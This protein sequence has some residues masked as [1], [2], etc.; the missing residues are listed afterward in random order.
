[1]HIVNSVTTNCASVV[2]KVILDGWIFH[3]GQKQNEVPYL[4]CVLFKKNTRLSFSMLPDLEFIKAESK[5]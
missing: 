4:H 1:M 3:L 5:M 2:T